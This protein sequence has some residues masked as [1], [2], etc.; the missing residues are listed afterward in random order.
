MRLFTL[1]LVFTVSFFWS[2]ESNMLDSDQQT[3]KSSLDG[4]AF[5]K[6][7]DRS[8]GT[9]IS[10][11]GDGDYVEVADDPSLDL[12]NSFTIAAWI[13]MESYTEWASVVTK[14]TGDNNY[15]IHQSG[16]V[17]GSEFGHLRFTGGSSSIP[18]FLESNTQI[19]LNEW[20]HIAVTYDG[21]ALT[22]YLDG[23]EDGSSALDVTLDTNDQPLL[24]GA[25]FPG[26][27]EFWH[28]AIDEV[29][30]WNEALG[31]HHIR[32]AMNGHSSP[33]ASALA[34]LWSFDEG[35]GSNAADRSTNNN[36]GILV[37][38]AGWITP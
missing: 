28:G 3:G 32:T 31:A 9:A 4:Q 14:G 8:R 19:P 26:A 29:K 11:D 20:H 22:F 7:A 24:I 30:I 12:P 21:A 13:Y 5:F 25:D 27:V 34:G 6:S 15:T 16:P 35:S 2:C 10:L 37:G 33:R 1:V 38:D 17:G 36:D 23:M 18:S